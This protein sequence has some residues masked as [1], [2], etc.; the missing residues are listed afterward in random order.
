[1]TDTICD[2]H[3]PPAAP[4]LIEALKSELVGASWGKRMT[5]ALAAAGIS[6]FMCGARRDD[7]RVVP[8]EVEAVIVTLDYM[9]G[10]PLKF[11][12]H[13]PIVER[14]GTIQ[15][16]TYSW[17]V[18]DPASGRSM[19]IDDDPGQAIFTALG[20]VAF[21][22]AT[23]GREGYDALVHQATDHLRQITADSKPAEGTK[24]G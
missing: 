17:T 21:S 3:A 18:S 8:F 2:L 14:N 4:G 10:G 16:G 1:M 24:N 9:A 19:S 5:E 23:R 20:K 12:I 6:R 13:R 22:I 7:G 15:L 11:A